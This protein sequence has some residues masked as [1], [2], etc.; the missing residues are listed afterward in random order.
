MNLSRN[1]Q[2]I[3]SGTLGWL[4]AGLMAM[5]D[6]VAQTIPFSNNFDYVVGTTV[7]SLTNAGWD[8]SSSLVQVQTNVICVDTSSV[9][10]PQNTALTNWM[11]PD[12]MTNVWTDLYAQMAFHDDSND[13]AATT[14]G[15]LK[16]FMDRTGYI[17]VYD[18]QNG[19][20]TLSNTVRGAPV[21]AY[22]NG[23][24]GRITLFQNYASNQCAVFLDGTLLKELLPFVSNVTACSRFRL[25]GGNQANSYFDNYSVTRAIPPN[26]TD[27]QEIDTYGYLAFKLN[28]GPSQPYTTIQSAVNA[29]LPRYTIHVTNGTYTENVTINHAIG[30]LTGGVFTINGTLAIAQDLSVSSRVGFTSGDL[31]LS[32]RSILAVTGSLIASNV[33]SFTGAVLTVSGSV[34]NRDMTLGTNSLT[35]FG[36]NLSGSNLTLNAGARLSVTGAVNAVDVTLGTGASLYAGSTLACH[37]L[38][39]SSGAT[40]TVVGALTATGGLTLGAN[41]V[42]TAGGTVSGSDLTLAA[43][44]RLTATGS[45]SVTGT[46]NIS[47][48]A[49]LVAN[50]QV[51]GHDIA[52]SGGLVI[53]AGGGVT[54]TNLTLGSGVTLALTNANVTVSNLVIGAGATLVVSNGTVMANGFT[55]TGSFTLDE[56]WG[57]ASAV[58][59]MPYTENFDSYQP[60]QPVSA[61]GWRGWRVADNSIAVEQGRYV[62]A[63]NGVDIG[64][65]KPLTN[66][67]NA[68]GAGQVWTDL[69]VI[70]T[71][72][73]NDATT[74]VRSTAALMAVISTNGYLSLYNRTSASWDE[75]RKDVWHHDVP[76][77][78]AGQWSRVSVLSDYNS[79]QCAVF[80]D[81]V[82]LRQQ[83]PFINPNLVS[84]T[85]FTLVNQQT[86]VVS[87]D[88]VYVGTAYP[89]TLT[90]DVNQTDIPDAVEVMSGFDILSFGSVYRIR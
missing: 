31:S 73:V 44:S 41:A 49:T 74:E 32:N 8:A 18:V 78:Q 40:G 63:S 34:T 9:I 66:R 39:E 25:D 47:A 61:L 7:Q 77:R 70:P 37:S 57:N 11:A 87:L 69:R 79:K 5:A 26:L 43:G 35:T 46:V 83:F 72:D 84:N 65:L 59:G 38:V 30:A 24:W 81:G 55:F 68:A 75:C 76:Q 90:N 16:L 48:T 33:T 15:V 29:A 54:A 14:S 21:T 36:Q 3:I 62:S 22:T 28:V 67:V 10:L 89:A 71:W 23:Q 52:I 86:N 88:N 20:L 17:K 80:L 19:W 12:P 60:G 45:L 64:Y 58:P 1:R 82:L 4:G 6:P 27:G 56:H 50:G 51:A 13:M 53:G 42:L 2:N 85:M